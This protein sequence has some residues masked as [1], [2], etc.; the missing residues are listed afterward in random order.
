M[1]EKN[2]I[3]KENE[4][5]IAVNKMNSLL[6][7]MG[8]VNCIN[9]CCCWCFCHTWSLNVCKFL[10]FLTNFAFN[11]Y[12]CLWWWCLWCLSHLRSI[13]VVVQNI[14]CIICKFDNPVIAL[15]PFSLFYFYFVFKIT[16]KI[17]R[18]SQKCYFFL[19]FTEN[20]MKHFHMHFLFTL[21]YFF[22]RNN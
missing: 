3:V 15:H 10:I 14:F 16:L 4:W 18:Y 17:S 2:K 11:S 7:M 5:E 12:E 1:W 22:R 8:W 21:F 19:F 6:L 9:Y 13:L 20:M